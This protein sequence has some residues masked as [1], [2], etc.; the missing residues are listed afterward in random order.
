MQKY[1]TRVVAGVRP[2]KAGQRVHNVPV[3]D[4]VADALAQHADVNTSLIAVP[5]SAVHAAAVEAIDARVPLI[6]ILTEHV[7]TSVSA[8]IVARARDAGVRVVGPSSVGIMSPRVG[9]IGAIGSS[10]IHE[11]FGPGRIGVISKSGGMT[12]EIANVL[13]RGGLGISTALGIGG[14]TIIGMD[15]AD[16]LR[17]FADDRETDAVVLFGEIG[18]TYEEQ[19]AEYLASG[20]YPKPVVATIAGRFTEQLPQGTILGHAGAI[21]A[22]GR[23]SYTS[24]VTALRASG[25]RIA[26]R[27]EEIPILLTQALYEHAATH[28][29]ALAGR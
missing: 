8:E 4:T 17:L 14:D 25:V 23:G 5:A 27:L 7:P 6:V 3:Y 24:K 22:K 11:V 10:E 26:D 20:V 29:L 13:S 12:A 16:A 19:A 2:G 28:Q 1:G 21:V 18:G 15:F 9:K